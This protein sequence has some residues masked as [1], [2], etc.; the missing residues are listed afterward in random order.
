M[1]QLSLAKTPVLLLA[2]LAALA[3]A[4][5]A[6]PVSS[7]GAPTAGASARTPAGFFGV[8]PQTGL[9][10]QDASYMKA[11]GIDTVRW[12]LLWA[13]IQPTANGPYHW[14]GFDETVAVAA[15]AGLRILP[16]VGSTPRWLARKETTLPVNNARQRRAWT[17]FLDAAVRRYGPGGEFWAQHAPGVVQYEPAIN[18][19]PIRDWQIWNEPNFFYFAY[20]VSPARYA[21]LVTISSKAIKRV[22]P[23]ANVLLA[24]LFGE[25][26]ARGKRGMP[27]A[28]FLD[29]LYQ[30]PGLKHRFDG[31]ALHPYAVDVEMLEELVAG[32]HAV[33][34][35]N[36]DRVGLYIT[37][38]GWG[39]Q[40]NFEQV[41]FEQGV[42]GQVRQLRGAYLYL[43]RNRHK[44]N[45]KQVHWFSWK[46]IRGACTFCDSVG[47]FRE[48][49]RFKPKPSWRAFVA[50]TG[51]RARP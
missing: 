9:T 39:S 22:Q 1:H 8:A 3:C 16:S 35:S 25:P 18:P 44:L 48:G 2:I 36:R 6:V 32:L 49:P 30:R 10:P 27:A 15:R 13:G 28:I 40:N 50:L 42:R 46:D 38:M 17:A 14:A 4:V 47:F 31:I 45:L 12:P 23:G 29:Q 51:G 5:V 19:M 7:S 33:T 43:I 34:V 26:T 41:A 21:K 37:E 20:P 11:G 24:G